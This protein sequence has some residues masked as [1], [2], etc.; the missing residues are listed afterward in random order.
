MALPSSVGAQL[1]RWATGQ[2]NGLFRPQFGRATAEQAK[3][4]SARQGRTV[5]LAGTA[6]G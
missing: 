3:T 1:A 4:A 6:D 5:P 2:L